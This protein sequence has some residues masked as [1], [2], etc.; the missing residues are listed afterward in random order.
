MNKNLKIGYYLTRPFSL[1]VFTVLVICLSLLISQWHRPPQ[2]TRVLNV[3]YA[4][5]A[6]AT[7]CTPHDRLLL[8]PYARWI[9]Q[10]DATT[11]PADFLN[12]WEKYVSDVQ[13]LSGIERVETGIAMLFGGIAVMN[14]NPAFASN[15]I[16]EYSKQAKIARI[17]VV[18]DWQNVKDV[19]SRYGVQIT[20]IKYSEQR[21]VW[22]ST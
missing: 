21:S 7:R 12:A 11:C 14:G 1:E 10:I 2:T 6:V 8:V 5:Q 17:A 20:P 16:P 9:A 15:A 22:R 19:A 18:T 3:L 4:Q 13:A